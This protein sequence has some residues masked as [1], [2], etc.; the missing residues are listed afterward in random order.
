MA[1][2]DITSQNLDNT[3]KTAKPVLIDFWAPW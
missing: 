3:L 1:V 2:L